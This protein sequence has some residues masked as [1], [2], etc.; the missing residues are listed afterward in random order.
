MN[1]LSSIRRPQVVRAGI[2]M[3]TSSRTD[4]PFAA[5]GGNGFANEQWK[6]FVARTSAPDA[7]LVHEN[8]LID[9]CKEIRSVIDDHDRHTALP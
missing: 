4:P 9:R 8:N 3:D 2:S 7:S 1:G 5:H 6:K